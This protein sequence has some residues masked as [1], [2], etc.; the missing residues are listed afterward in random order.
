MRSLIRCI[1]F[2][3]GLNFTGLAVIH[4][5]MYLSICC[6]PEMYL[7]YIDIVYECRKF[8]SSDLINHG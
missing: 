1:R 7:A 8:S 4:N 5:Y 3:R 6:V 2:H